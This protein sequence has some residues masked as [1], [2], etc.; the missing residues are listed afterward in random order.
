MA[1]TSGPKLQQRKGGAVVDE[2]Q[3]TCMP[4]VGMNDLFVRQSYM[5][6]LECIVKSPEMRMNNIQG[7]CAAYL[8]AYLPEG[9]YGRYHI[10][11]ISVCVSYT[12]CFPRDGVMCGPSSLTRF[13]NISR[14]RHITVAP[15]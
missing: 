15:P 13:N 9:L 8:A 4:H 3:Y 11:R 12:S 2:S 1:T 14:R 10:D 5:I 6:V 7:G